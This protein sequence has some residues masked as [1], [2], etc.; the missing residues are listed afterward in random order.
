MKN[1][2]I[3]VIISINESKIN[4]AV[5]NYVMGK[6]VKMTTEELEILVK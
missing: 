2:E 3:N 5:D 1:L 4:R 6:V